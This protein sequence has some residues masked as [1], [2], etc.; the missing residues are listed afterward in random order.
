MVLRREETN[1]SW[2]P[3]LLQLIEACPHV[4]IAFRPGTAAYDVYDAHAHRWTPI[5]AGRLEASDGGLRYARL[6]PRRRPGLLYGVA[7]FSRSLVPRGAA[8]RQ[9]PA[10]AAGEPIV[11][12]LTRIRFASI[13]HVALV[14]PRPLI[15]ALDL[16]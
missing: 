1:A 4:V 2:G 13:S 10:A 12:V 11:D 14:A 15:D 6:Q 8:L 5:E 3:L 7:M 16:V 9:H